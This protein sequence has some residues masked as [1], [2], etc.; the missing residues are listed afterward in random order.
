MGVDLATYRL[1]IG[2][3]FC[4]FLT[5]CVTTIVKSRRNINAFLLFGGI[6]ISVILL[7]CGDIEVNPGPNKGK[8]CAACGCYSLER[9]DVS[10]H[11]FS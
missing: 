4:G 11:T 8:R 10:F 7:S 3:F 2:L 5:K 1:R 6:V 9:T